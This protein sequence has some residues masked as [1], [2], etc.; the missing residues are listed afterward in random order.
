MT[1]FR[2][3][4]KR[5][6]KT[7]NNFKLPFE[8]NAFTIGLMVLLGEFLYY[9]FS[10]KSGFNG[11]DLF[12]VITIMQFNPLTWVVLAVILIGYWLRRY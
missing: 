9:F 8:L 4:T 12:L 2:R 6:L 3:H 5:H 7:N 10:L 1:H 11:F